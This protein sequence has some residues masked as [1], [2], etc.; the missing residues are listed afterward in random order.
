[1]Y[2]NINLTVLRPNYL[3]YTSTQVKLTAEYI[4]IKACPINSDMPIPLQIGLIRH[5]R[6]GPPCIFAPKQS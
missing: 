6:T 2:Y 5:M 4:A 3:K 1:M